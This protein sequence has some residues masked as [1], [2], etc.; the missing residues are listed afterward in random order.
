MSF[1]ESAVVVNIVGGSSS[2]PA[3][4]VFPIAPPATGMWAVWA[5]VLVTTAGAAGTVAINVSWNNGVTSAGLN[6][7][8]FSLTSQGEQAALVGNLY[9]IN[10]QPITY[11]TTVSSASGSPVYTIRLRFQFLG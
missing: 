3:T 2:I 5:D 9:A 7:T 6:S 4:N 11:A 8:A 1:Q 10:T